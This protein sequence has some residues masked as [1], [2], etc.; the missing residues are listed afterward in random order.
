MGGTL[1]PWRIK[2]VRAIFAVLGMGVGGLMAW[3]GWFHQMENHR[4]VAGW[5]KT[6]CEVVKWEV[7]V[8]RGGYGTSV[9][10]SIL[11]RYEFGGRVYRG[12]NYDEA[13]DWEV[14]MRDFEKE[15]VAARRGPS[16]CHVDPQRPFM[17]SFR[18][19]RIW[20]PWS[21]IGGGLLLVVAGLV[22]MVLTFLPRVRTRPVRQERGGRYFCLFFGLGM[23]VTGG[24]MG[25]QGGFADAIRGQWVRARLAEVPA[26]IESS[27]V[28]Q[29]QG[30]G[31]KS[32]MTYQM[33]RVVYSYD[34]GGRRWHSDRWYADA[35]ALQGG[36]AE[37]AR[38]LASRHPEGSE[39]KAWI[40]PDEPWH[41][42]LEPGLRWGMVKYLVPAILIIGGAALLREA[43]R[44]WW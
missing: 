17:A 20:F 32:H 28:Y 12:S 1:A 2:T 16:F 26:K 22:F 44:M 41:A 21:L 43:K 33:V 34:F 29:R 5:V 9:N 14:D 27:G 10:R 42:V 3:A 30:T 11:Y 6:P 13:T 8:S 36:T 38:E 15:G 37:Q 40:I 35:T 39:A 31:R 4:K 7:D 24:V 18:G 25:W 23:L 19:A